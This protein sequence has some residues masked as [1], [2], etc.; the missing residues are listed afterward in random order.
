MFTNNR[1][2]IIATERPLAFEGAFADEN[3]FPNFQ[4]FTTAS[5]DPTKY[6]V[7][8]L[9]PALWNK[10]LE[11]H[12]KKS[13]ATPS[14]LL[15]K[16]PPALTYSK[17]WWVFH[18][19]PNEDNKDNLALLLQLATQAN[20]KRKRFH[21]LREHQ[22]SWRTQEYNPI[23]QLITDL[24][25]SCTTAE[26][27]TD[28][29]LPLKNLKNI[30]E[31]R[32]ATIV[33]YDNKNKPLFGLYSENLQGHQELKRERDFE[34]LPEAFSGNES[35]AGVI[36]NDGVQATGI[37]ALTKNPWSSCMTMRIQSDIQQK[38]RGGV[39]YAQYF[40]FRRELISFTEKDLWLFEL[41][42]GP[43]ALALEKILML[44]TINRASKEWRSTFDAI[45]EPVT[46]VDSTFRII[47][48]NKAF[49]EL[50]NLD[51]KKIKDKKCYSLLAS[52][53]T[54]CNNCPA[55][56]SEQEL[57]TARI[58]D[59]SKNDLIAWS[60]GI[61]LNDENYHFQFYRNMAKENALMS[62]LVQSEKLA[63]L[64]K[65]VS[66]IA[67]EINNPLAGILATSQ[68]MLA[69]E[70]GL[71][72]LSITEEIVEIK[73]S[74]WRSKK[75]I[76]D[77][78]GFTEEFEKILEQVDINDSIHTALTF[79]KSALK[80]IKLKTELQNNLPKI[81][82]SS[83]SIQQAIFNLVTNAVHAMKDH[84]DLFLRSSFNTQNKEILIEVTDSGP[85]IP[86]EKLKNIFDPFYTSKAE[87]QGTG[88]GLSIVK[89]L[90]HKINAKISVTS[91]LGAG[92][93]FII[94][95]P[96]E[97]MHG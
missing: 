91:K 44:I 11:T 7:L 81:N 9:E 30:C 61:D 2:G 66:A 31:F 74:A 93:S 64:G 48:A 1:I 42:H 35:T 72:K 46:V 18:V 47:K 37:S 70:E 17:E 59:K 97:R 19:S 23:L 24:T 54:P 63:A 4:A 26:D 16:N 3:Y 96:V 10:K 15:L 67:H 34:F 79:S 77:L 41:A 89:N 69:D 53:K 36:N 82:S 92:T 84:G 78:L 52:R 73:S 27:F 62:A 39:Q 80:N 33:F 28:L 45:S 58:K 55:M 95:I 51:I 57:K 32:D 76:D 94:S 88:L 56:Q 90:L 29:L 83:S 68:L 60:Y 40:L 71:Q 43:L 20:R 85:G 75:I 25:K 13:Q 38:K 12:L 87:G 22:N 65:L 49:A 86:E 50:I 5:N 21:A 14:I 6:D 8:I